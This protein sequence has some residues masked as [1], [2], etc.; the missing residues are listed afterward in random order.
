VAARGRS[1]SGK[2]FRVDVPGALPT[3]AID[4]R[5]A[6]AAARLMLIFTPEL[7]GARDPASVLATVIPWV[8]AVQVR[9]KPL[10]AGAARSAPSTAAETARWTRTLLAL[11]AELRVP[12]LVLVNDRV[13]VARRFLA[14]GVDGVHLGQDD[15]PPAAA[16]ALLG[17]DALIGWST[18]SLEQVL[19]AEEL[20]VDYLGF[21]PVNATTTKG[22]AEGLGS[23]RAWIAST[24]TARPVFPIGGIARE[25]AQELAR[26]GR[27]AVGAAVLCA[28]DPVKAVR[29]LAALLAEP[30]E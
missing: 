3:A 6:L 26:I 24:A 10:A 19:E 13:D 23:E 21:G 29:E 5:A 14:D 8:D 9:P 4:R 2:V 11:R 28:P 17:P 18:H 25:N 27:A 30:D 1:A 16:R 7:C 20:D 22:Y 15:C 12:C